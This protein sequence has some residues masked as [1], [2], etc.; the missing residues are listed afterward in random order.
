VDDT[1]D[2]QTWT[3]VI[4]VVL[5]FLA[6]PAGMLVYDLRRRRGQRAQ[7][8]AD[9]RFTAAMAVVPP[10]SYQAG[11]RRASKAPSRNP[12]QF[13]DRSPPRRSEAGRP[14]F[15]LGGHFHDE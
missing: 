3:I 7:R 9:S 8:I 6:L 4:A 13:A 11:A 5:V 14:P 10:A 15:P 12:T 1:T 2:V